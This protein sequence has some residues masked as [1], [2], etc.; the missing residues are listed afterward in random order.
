MQVKPLGRNYLVR[1]DPGEQAIQRLMQFAD[2]HR[3]R[4]ATFSG[5]GTFERAT[6]G[7]Y[8]VETQHYQNELFDEPLEVLGLAGNIA[9]GEEGE[10]IVHAHVTVGRSDYTT[11]GGHLVEATVGPT[12]EIRVET[13][14]STIRRRH[15]PESGL[16]LWDLE[17]IETY[18][19]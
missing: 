13:W 9:R 4:F 7:Y 16:Q 1:L 15:D 10:R 6:L 14:P 5:I 18:S 12:L 11:L 8:D 17:A 2:H 3:I 19:V